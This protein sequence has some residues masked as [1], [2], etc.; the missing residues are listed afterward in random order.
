M[1]DHK[2]NEILS[3]MSGIEIPKLDLDEGNMTE[4]Q[5]EYHRPHIDK[6]GKQSVSSSFAP[7]Q[8]PRLPYSKVIKTIDS[9]KT[10]KEYMYNINNI[11]DFLERISLSIDLPQIRVK[12]KHRNEVQICYCH[13]AFHNIINNYRMIYNNQTELFNM[14]YVM[15][16]I[17]KQY[18]LKPGFK[19]SYNEGV[20]SIPILENWTTNLPGFKLSIPQFLPFS[21]EEDLAFP[22]FLMPPSALITFVYEFNLKL[23][24]LIRMR[25]KRGD[26]WICT[27]YTP[28]YIE[29][30][31]GTKNPISPPQMT[32]IYHVITQQEKKSWRLYNRIDYSYFNYVSIDAENPVEY[33][34]HEKIPL[35]SNSP[36]RA[37]HWVVE[38]QEYVALNNKSNYTTSDNVYIGYHPWIRPSLIQGGSIRIDELSNEY[39]DTSEPYYST[40]RSPNEKGYGL[41]V[42]NKKAMEKYHDTTLH[43]P[44]SSIKLKVDIVNTDP[45]QQKFEP[46]D[47]EDDEDEHDVSSVY[48]PD[49]TTGERKY[50]VKVRLLTMRKVSFVKDIENEDYLNGLD[51]EDK[52]NIP[53]VIRVV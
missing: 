50:K 13:N 39:L 9:L 53:Y 38:N 18:Y 17:Y 27:K 5:K 24:S 26:D 49:L 44:D 21:E 7:V 36:C 47:D 51:D 35:T 29:T 37:I 22:L 46:Y 10:S 45:L 8:L 25:V 34:K 32:A 23:S 48:V 6:D 14:D 43:L 41:F 42:I 30:S 12:E 16:D 4:L 33:K 11:Y 19:K 3:K 28:K 40:R 2:K 15:M 52:I 1:Q 20:G 31:I